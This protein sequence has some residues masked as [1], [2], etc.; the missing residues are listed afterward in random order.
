MSSPVK[1]F[2]VFD[3]ES[4]LRVAF[5]LARGASR[6]SSYEKSNLFRLCYE[7]RTKCV[8]AAI[9][10]GKAVGSVWVQFVDMVV[11]GK[12]LHFSSALYADLSASYAVRF[13]RLVGVVRL[14]RL[15]LI[16]TVH[17]AN[18]KYYEIYMGINYKKLWRSIS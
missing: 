9:N 1:N 7:L 10:G 8:Q 17:I 11:H 15:P 3:E 13:P 6:L 18:N 2:D 12:V 5:R 16:P 14:W 4:A